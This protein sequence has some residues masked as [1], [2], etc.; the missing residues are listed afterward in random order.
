MKKFYFLATALVALAS[1]TNDEF[2]GDGDITQNISGRDNNA[3][4]FT[5]G[6]NTLTRAD[7]VG[8]DAAGLLNKKFIVGGFK[9]TGT[10]T[11][12][13]GTPAD[14]VP[15]TTT[16][17]DN[18][19][20]NWKENTAATTE[21]NTSDWEYAGLTALAPSTLANNTQSIKYWDYSTS[22]YDFIAYSTGNAAVVTE[23]TESAII[24]GNNSVMVTA[25]D[26]AN[27][28]KTAGA[29][30]LTG[31]IDQLAKCYIA[32][33]VTAYKAT[34][35]PAQPKY[36][37]EI[38]LTFR[39]LASKVRMAIYETIPGYSVKDVEFYQ[40]ATTKL[41]ADIN[42]NTTAT[43]FAV[44]NAD[45]DKFYTG[46]TY[47]IKFPTI[48]SS[49]IS[50]SD[51]NKAHV[52]LSA[53]GV[54]STTKNF[55]SMNY[56]DTKG[57]KEKTGGSIWLGRSSSA[58]TYAG[59]AGQ[60]Y[61]SIV[62]PNEEGTVLELRVNYTLE[63][64][65]GSG[66]EIKIYGATAF[67]PAIYATWKP[68]YAYTYIFKI[69]DNT[70]GWTNSADAASNSVDPA[71]LYPITFDAIVV[72]SEEHTQSTITTVSTPT[73]TTYQKGHDITKDEYSA[74]TGDIY[75]Q[76]MQNDVLKNDLNSKGQLYSLSAAKTEA[77]VMDALN[78]QTASDA[79]KVTGRNGL[80]LTKVDTSLPTTIPG[81]DGNDITVATNT[82]AK[83][84]PS[85]N[86][87][88]AYVYDTGTDNADTEY[89]TAVKLTA[90]PADWNASDN[91]YYTDEACTQKANTTYADG[92]Y[93]KK[94][95]NLNKV[96]AVKVIKVVS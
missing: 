12:L 29:Y 66:E 9:G 2:V 26:A 62:M 67:V 40:D 23:G 18:Y 53:N 6:T 82:A 42:G 20:V 43:L 85:A 15:A 79:S 24:S 31:H 78:I 89:T 83:F 5:S 3:I 35:D 92:T 96:Y 51:Y 57:Y 25:I 19:Q 28:G 71:G 38:K 90:A 95:T 72:D 88:Y 46:G 81:A 69:S 1:C 39:S 16:V 33:M 7:H 87:T 84:N 56:T 59:T 91:V 70:N 50:N 36:Q 41:N 8:A 63:S 86:T 60:N 77:E 73:I 10:S 52:A 93:Y 58:A 17:F 49:N 14:G 94:Y 30:K 32:D 34:M 48:G 76:V 47:T 74:A 61:Y 21:S 64:V 75:V 22:Q 68:N 13:S 27:A 65:D 45:K 11:V 4:V 55:G 37:D 44:G 80:V 54:T